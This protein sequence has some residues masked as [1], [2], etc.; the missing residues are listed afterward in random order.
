M[1]RFLFSICCLPL[2]F[3]SFWLGQWA[4][5]KHT[6]VDIPSSKVTTDCAITIVPPCTD[7]ALKQS[8]IEALHAQLERISAATSEAPATETPE[9]PVETTTSVAPMPSPEVDEALKQAALVREKQAQERLA[10]LRDIDTT[11][12]TEAD[13][14]IHRDYLASLEAE[15]A[16]RQDCYARMDAGEEITPEEHQRLFQLT[17]QTMQL[18]DAEYSLLVG[19]VGTS[20]GLSREESIEFTQLI[21]QIY[22]HLEMGGTQISIEIV[23]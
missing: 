13:Q 19:A 5:T 12:L 8:E 6:E 1:K 14:N 17:L 2:L 7:C 11:L 21:R 10:F 20:M 18:R 4:V 15:I 23:D 16:L 22:T 9:V 3:I